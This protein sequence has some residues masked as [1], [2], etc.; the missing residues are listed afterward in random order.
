MRTDPTDT[1]LRIP[2]VLKRT[3]LSLLALRLISLQ[4]LRPPSRP[5]R[6]HS[7]VLTYVTP[8]RCLRCSPGRALFTCA[9]GCYLFPSWTSL[10]PAGSAGRAMGE[11]S[12]VCV[13]TCSSSRAIIITTVA[14]TVIISINIIS[15]VIIFVI[16][17]AIGITSCRPRDSG[18]E[19]PLLSVLSISPS[20]LLLIIFSSHLIL[21]IFLLF[22]FSS[23]TSLLICYSYSMSSS[24]AVIS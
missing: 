8:W 16:I 13:C 12:A 11:C 3:P 4:L 1:Y 10:T 22:L 14:I 17:I 5:P 20:H 24:S 21:S 19:G 18:Y 15:I 23:T 7:P 9:T 2:Q 6:R